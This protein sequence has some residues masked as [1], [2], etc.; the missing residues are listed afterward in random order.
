MFSKDI[1]SSLQ[2]ILILSYQISRQYIVMLLS[3]FDLVKKILDAGN[4]N[5]DFL[6]QQQMILSSVFDI[7]RGYTSIS[8]LPPFSADENSRVRKC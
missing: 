7:S 2:F 3:K 4:V 6:I 8:D 1:F 5:E